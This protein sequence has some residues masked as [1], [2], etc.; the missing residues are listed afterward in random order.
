MTAY[1]Y[2]RKSVVH[3]AARMLSPETQEAAIRG[4]PAPHGHED[5]VILRHLDVSG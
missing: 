1:G 3:D 5:V 4:Q 2:I